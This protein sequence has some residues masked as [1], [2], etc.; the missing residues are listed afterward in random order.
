MRFI[1]NHHSINHCDGSPPN[2]SRS[3]SPTKAD[4]A[5]RVWMWWWKEAGG[6]SV[7]CWVMVRK[8]SKSCSVKMGIL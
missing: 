4:E 3:I 8:A 2:C 1:F 5:V 6:M 7:I